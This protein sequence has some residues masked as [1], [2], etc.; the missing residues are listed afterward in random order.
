MKK[1]C[2]IILTVFGVGITLCL[3]AGSLSIIGFIFALFVGGETATEICVF[4]HKTYFP[5][6]IMFSSFFSGVGLLG[7]YLKK[8]K[9]LTFESK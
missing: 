3:F 4:I 2:N 6:V 7:L 8:I 5:I 1:L 9:A